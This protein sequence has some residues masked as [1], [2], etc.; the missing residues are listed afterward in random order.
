VLA[1]DQRRAKV[2]ALLKKLPA[3]PGGADHIAALA[4]LLDTII[5][6]IGDARHPSNWK[7]PDYRDAREELLK[8][9]EA[10]DHLTPIARLA[11]TSGPMKYPVFLRAVFRRAADEVDELRDEHLAQDRGGQT[12]GRGPD[13]RARWIADEAASA[14]LLVTATN[15]PVLDFYATSAGH[16]FHELVDGLLRLA[17]LRSGSGSQARAAAERLKLRMGKMRED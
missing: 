7:Q 16:P 5:G 1:P 6:T 12:R 15:P 17:R 13:V 4:R 10:V 9:A 3:A 2:E 14:W 8:I 11:L